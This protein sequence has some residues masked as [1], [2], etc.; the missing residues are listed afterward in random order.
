MLLLHFCRCTRLLLVSLLPLRVTFDAMRASFV[1][2][3]G[4]KCF[5]LSSQF[6]LE[7]EELAGLSALLEPWR[8]DIYAPLVIEVRH[9]GGLSAMKYDGHPEYSRPGACSYIYASATEQ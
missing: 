9:L 3:V 2:V 4:G 8:R 5:M 7:I 1:S 6:L